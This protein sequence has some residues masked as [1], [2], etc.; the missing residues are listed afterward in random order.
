MLYFQSTSDLDREVTGEIS[1][2]WYRLAKGS[3][4]LGMLVY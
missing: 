3:P 2:A 1:E 4:G